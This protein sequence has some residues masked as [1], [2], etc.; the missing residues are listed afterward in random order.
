MSLNRD[1]AGTSFGQSPV[2]AGLLCIARWPGEDE[3]MRHRYPL[4]AVA[5]GVGLAATGAVLAHF[6]AGGPWAVAGAVIGAVTGAFAPPVYDGMRDQTGKR[7]ALLASLEKTPPH[8]WARLRDPRRELVGFVGRENEL[9]ALVAWCEDDDAER[10]RLVTG[11]GGVGKTR[12]AVELAARMTE[13]GWISERIANGKEGEAIATLRAVT[14]GRA[15]LVVDYAETRVGLDRMMAALVGEESD[16]TRVL[17][18]A[19]WAGNWWDQIG[20]GEPAVWDLVQA[21]RSAELV[22]SPAP[23]RP[24]VKIT[25]TLF[26]GRPL[27]ELLLEA[28]RYG[29]QQRA[30]PATDANWEVRMS[31]RHELRV[32]TF[33]YYRLP[34]AD[35]RDT[36]V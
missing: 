5:W 7:Q 14:S 36:K 10:M 24:P 6:L 34:L 15:L 3:G 13:L 23:C 32:M 8:S 30:K 21:A 9:A 1:Y 20:V 12:L 26:E 27:R 25:N 22:L 33:Q 16:R 18:L 29:E 35:M 11:P 31:T 17:L 2:P 4:R 19:R 28:I